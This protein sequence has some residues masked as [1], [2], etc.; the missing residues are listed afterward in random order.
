MKTCSK[1]TLNDNIF[2]VRINDEGLCNYC[3]Q[4]NK[5]NQNIS[6]EEYIE[7][8]NQLMEAF[9]KYRDRP[10]QV[11]LAYSGG[12]DS[13][14]TLY[15]LREKFDVS[16]LAVTFDNGFIT[17]QCRQNIHAAT[18]NLNVDSITIKP[19]FAKLA[20]AFSLAAS[21]EIYP[22]KSLERA[23]SI[24]TACIGL[25]KSAVYK[26][27]IL[28]K[29]PFICFGWT[30]GQ[31]Q[32][33][34]PVMKLDY[35]MILANQKQIL[36]PLV[37]HLGDEY[38]N[39]F[40]DPEWIEAQKEYVPSLA[41]PLVFSQYDE[42]EIISTIKSIGWERP[43]D[44]DMNSTNCLLNSYANA[45]HAR[46]YGYNPYSLEIAALVREGFLSREEGLKKLSV[47]GEDSVINHVKTELDKYLKIQF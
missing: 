20:K 22:K 9:D 42:D 24:C 27:A 39:Y 32:V 11:V 30:P 47:S 19:S 43:Q 31:V 23:S 25:V 46:D 14:F 44:T 1:C 45:I 21:K 16:V 10:Y 18:A 17:E 36:Q 35:R 41:Y 26:E 8:E 37:K 2:S 29:I 33:K 5:V 28:R 34:N 13:T 7:K 12:K 3:L 4:N 6:N 40:V 15:K 38:K